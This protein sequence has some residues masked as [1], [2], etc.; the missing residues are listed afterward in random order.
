VGKPDA[1]RTEIVVAFVILAAG[2]EA[3][4]ALATELQD[5]SKALTAPYQ[6][7]REI[8]FVTELR[9]RLRDGD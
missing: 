9:G 1:E 2:R 6:Y 3:S 5:H 7:P 4:D 8:H